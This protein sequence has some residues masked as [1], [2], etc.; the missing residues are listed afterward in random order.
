MSTSRT[1]GSGWSAETEAL[2]KKLG[3]N[4][5]EEKA[6]DDE[7]KD[8]LKVIYCSRTHSQLSQFASE[9]RKVSM[10]P[11]I[12]PL[13]ED[14]DTSLEVTK[15]DLRTLTLGSRKNL[16]INPKVN[17]LKS[18]AA[19]N[20]RCLELQKPGTAA[21]HKCPYMPTKE[22]QAVV[23]DFRDAALANI[24]DIE[25]LGEI[26][27]QMRICS[28]YASRS[29]I[30]PAEVVTL[31][32]PL[33]LQKSAR[34]AL[35]LDLKDHVVI[36]DEAHNLMDAISSLYSADVSLAQLQ[37][38]KG[39]LMTYLQ[40]F[41]NR[42][43][44]K[45]RVYV[46]QVVRLVD[47]LITFLSSTMNGGGGT[48]SAERTISNTDLMSGKGVDQ[49]D[50][51]KLSQYLQES[52]LARK[53]DGYVEF[54]AIQEASNAKVKNPTTQVDKKGGIPVLQHIQSFLLVLMNPS[55]EGRFFF[56]RNDKQEA[57]LRYMLLDPSIH[58]SDIVKE[59]RAVILAG[60]TM[61][62]MD[63]YTSHLFPYLPAE[64]ISTLSCGHVIPKTNLVACPIS[65]GPNSEVFDFTFEKRSS[66]SM[67]AAAGR[68]LLEFAQ[69]I[70]D[71]LVA[72]F[73]S[74][75]Y[76]DSC[77]AT[78]KK[79]VLDNNNNGPTTIWQQ[80]NTIKP[81]FAESS[82][83]PATSEQGPPQPKNQST[84][85]SEKL[86]ESY[87]AAILSTSESHRGALLLSVIGGSLSEGINFSD[88]LGR[89]VIVFGL[90]FPNPH[91]A[92]WRA[93]TEYVSQKVAERARQN[94]P[95]LSVSQAEAL[96]KSAAREFYENATM[97]AVN[98]AVGRAIRH[99]GDYAAILM[100]DRRY[101]SERI[102]GKLPGWIQG[103]L[104]GGEGAVGDVKK[105]VRAFFDGKKGQ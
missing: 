14:N 97:R 11:S 74:Y 99:K 77:I 1:N 49:I 27:K 102:R 8:E 3:M 58:F 105:R 65:T 43:K 76:L 101:A 87:T 15:E 94:N 23:N 38:G 17:R 12:E 70:P 67:I 56:S 84:Q 96:G 63:D 55:K 9:L 95:S 33:L 25:E 31:P 75:A 103:S 37:R 66:T 24:R 29:A 80:L 68:T 16:C 22:D 5:S 64:K 20:E 93:K 4:Q 35:D 46:A 92:E 19:I 81:I 30:K 85:S 39:Q 61:S 51:Y 86:L 26:G 104:V 13:P 50:V 78:W 90:P 91:T 47:S 57:M 72:F 7:A 88:T 89:G 79:T 42:L 6:Q 83:S 82:R 71:G 60:G 40:K 18:V 52:R 98:Q 53:V 69:V 44:G 54:S 2:M 36:V 73:P 34:E 62:P 32:Y 45:N 100:V 28:Y 41:R 59:A 21:E 10:P 48:G